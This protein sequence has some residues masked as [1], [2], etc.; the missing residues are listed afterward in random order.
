MSRAV[1]WSIKGVDFDAREAAKEAARR[2]GLSL[3]EWI[4]RAISERAAE[5]GTDGQDFDAD[6]RL[7]AVAAQLALLSRESEA[8]GARAAQGKG[9]ETRVVDDR[10]LWR[11][12]ERPRAAD[13]LDDPVTEN[14]PRRRPARAPRQEPRAVPAARPSR[15][16]IDAEAMLEKAVAAFESRAERA[17]ARAARALAQ[18]ADRVAERIDSAETERVEMLAHVEYRLADLETH[19]RRKDRA[20]DVEPLRGALAQVAERIDSAETERAEMLSQVENRLADLE[21]H[22]RKKAHSE[23]EP[24]RGALGRLETRLEDL[25][26]REP[27]PRDE[28]PA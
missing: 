28:N 6:E 16:N 23:V 27:E 9:R 5:A 22:L 19:L 25:A 10:P 26:S 20:S 12:Q 4:N 1:P 14:E 11:P 13:D 24:L 17:E 21:T 2:D 18:V 15:E 3:G 7:E 8:G